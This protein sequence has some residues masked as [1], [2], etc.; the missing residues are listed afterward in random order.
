MRILVPQI[1]QPR[2][3][4]IHREIPGVRNLER[5]V[6]QLLGCDPVDSFKPHWRGDFDHQYSI[7]AVEGKEVVGYAQYD[8]REFNPEQGN[9]HATIW[10]LASRGMSAEMQSVFFNEVL[11][12]YIDLVVRRAAMSPALIDHPL[13]MPWI[14]LRA[15]QRNWAK[16][17][18]R[19][20]WKPCDTLGDFNETPAGSKCTVY[21]E[22][23]YEYIA[24]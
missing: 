22:P 24:G 23:P 20:G 11:E 6:A 12:K 21:Y 14:Y 10:S 4:E 15:G 9:Y 2:Y 8:F 19:R 13:A 7:I 16:L 18:K 3:G 5:S 1:L 17:I